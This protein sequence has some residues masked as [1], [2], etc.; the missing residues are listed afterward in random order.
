MIGF[1][2][3]RFLSNHISLGDPGNPFDTKSQ[4]LCDSLTAREGVGNLR[5]FQV[6]L[7]FFIF[8]A[9]NMK[10]TAFPGG[11]LSLQHSIKLTTFWILRILGFCFRV[12]Q[13]S[14]SDLWRRSQQLISTLFQKRSHV[15]TNLAIFDS[16]SSF[17][18]SKIACVQRLCCWLNTLTFQKR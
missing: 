18:M 17:A 16:A 7:W 9:M 8:F 13:L 12:Q 4:Q 10:V 11:F 2:L 14:A 6:K 3:I 5:S 15:N 1:Y